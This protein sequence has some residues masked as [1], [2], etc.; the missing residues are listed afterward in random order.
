MQNMP[1]LYSLTPKSLFTWDSI[2]KSRNES[3]NLTFKWVSEQGSLSLPSG[4]NFEIEKGSMFK[5][6]WSLIEGSETIATANKLS[7]FAREYEICM[8]NQK[9][10]LK[11]QSMFSRCFYLESAGNQISSISPNNM[12]TRNSTLSCSENTPIELVGFMC[13]LTLISWRR[14]ASKNN[15]WIA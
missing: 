10:N 1:T 12:F 6:E 15:S 2:L 9:F 4:R 13:W 8:F 14:S 5:G 3:M 7:A 11:A